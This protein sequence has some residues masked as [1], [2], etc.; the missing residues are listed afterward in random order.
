V[1]SLGEHHNLAEARS[2]WP[3][4]VFQGN[5]PERILRAGTPEE[6]RQAVKNCLSQGGGHKHILNLNHGVDRTTPPANFQAYVDTARGLIWFYSILISICPFRG[7]LLLC[8][9]I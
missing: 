2:R 4:L 3:H 7:F 5:V 9:Y 6:V 1:V 8:K